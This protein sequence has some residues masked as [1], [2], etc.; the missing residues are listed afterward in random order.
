MALSEAPS[1]LAGA[2]VWLL[3]LGRREDDDAGVELYA[4]P[5]AP[6]AAAQG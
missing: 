4:G 3:P 1:A 6:H 5:L 2:D